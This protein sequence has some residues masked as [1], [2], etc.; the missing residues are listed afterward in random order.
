[1]KFPSFKTANANVC[2]FLVH[3]SAAEKTECHMSVG[4]SVVVIEVGDAILCLWQDMNGSIV[5]E[6]LLKCVW[7]SLGS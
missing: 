3:V 1:M 7:E 6:K 4:H 5:G 2:F